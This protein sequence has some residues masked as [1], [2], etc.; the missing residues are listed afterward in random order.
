[1]H[2]ILE[3]QIYIHIRQCRFYYNTVDRVDFNTYIVDNTNTLKNV[4]YG[5]FP[6]KFY[7]RNFIKLMFIF[8]A[9]YN[10]NIKSLVIAKH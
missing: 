6:K 3:H 8:T 4:Y 2:T 7:L 5:S 10:L 1:M 9:K